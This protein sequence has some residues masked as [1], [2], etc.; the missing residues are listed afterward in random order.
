LPRELASVVWGPTQIQG[1]SFTINLESPDSIG[2]NQVGEGA[3]VPMAGLDFTSITYTPVK[4]G[5]AI[6]ITRE[7]MEDS[8][9]ELLNKNISAAGIKFAENETALVLTALD[10]ANTTITGGA[11][12]TIANITAAMLAVENQDYAPTDIIIGLEALSDLRNIDTFVEA[13]KAGNTNLMQRNFIGTL[14]GMTVAKFSTNAS[15]TTTYAKYAYVF[16][17][18]QAYGI[19]IKRD[20]TVENFDMPTYDMQ[21]AV[22][23]QRIEVKLHRSKS[24]C[25]ITTT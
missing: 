14:Y 5:V 22:L 25:K 24:V 7:M 15:P 19:A 4:Y 10:G 16:D 18:S 17:R 9:F 6:R 8:Q 3:E 12:I 13:D 21:G 23:T 2:I 20:L 1:S 11:S